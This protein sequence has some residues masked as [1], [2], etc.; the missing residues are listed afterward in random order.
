MDS[1]DIIVAKMDSTANEI[2]SVKVHSFPTLKF[3]P[4][5]E[6]RTVSVTM[7]LDLISF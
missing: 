5:G 7:V 1:A 2:D 4:A 6:D 3:F